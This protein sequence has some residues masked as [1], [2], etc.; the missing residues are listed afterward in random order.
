[1]KKKQRKKTSYQN[2][3][4]VVIN[5]DIYYNT[6][7]EENFETR[8]QCELYVFIIQIEKSVLNSTASMADG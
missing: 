7:E 8:V 1:M 6:L 3:L 4:N 5:H 2:T